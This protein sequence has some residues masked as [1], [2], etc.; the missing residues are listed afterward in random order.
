MPVS[1]SMKWCFTTNNYTPANLATLRELAT[2]PQV[3]YLV[4]GFETA[5]DTGTP[6]LQGFCL[7]N[8]RKR[9][10]TVI[11]LI[12][13]HV[14]SANGTPYQAAVYCKK[15]GRFEE[16]GTE[17]PNN[18]PHSGAGGQWAVFAQWCF[19]FHRDNQ[20]NPTPRDLA[21]TFPALLG[22]NRNG[23]L[24]LID[25]LLPTP[26]L[27]EGELREWQIDLNNDLHQDPDDRTVRFI[28]DKEGG[29]GKSFFVRWFW[30]NNKDKSQI[31]SIGKIADIAF[32]VDVT[33][34][35]FLFNVPRDTMQY[36]QYPVL[37]A[38]KDRVIFSPKFASTTKMLVKI[39]HVVVFTNEDVNEEKMTQ[40]R[41]W[42]TYL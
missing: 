23:C 38:L 29:K 20:R 18:A 32:A 41:Y 15:T 42:I 9:K 12:P 21:S 34:S 11:T 28:V 30:S 40:D 19:D 22:R 7:F 10:E 13:G 1:Q 26:H 25:D 35:V 24:A 37:E 14:I 36:L 33:K 2:N 4:Y 3:D 17:P 31:L 5:P 8:V 16:H 27:Q 6:H 39:P